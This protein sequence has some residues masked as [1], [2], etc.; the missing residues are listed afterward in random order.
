MEGR[1]YYLLY[2]GQREQPIIY[3]VKKIM[4]RAEYIY[5]FINR[6]IYIYI[7]IISAGIIL[8][9]IIFKEQRDNAM[10]I[11]KYDAHMCKP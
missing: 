2:N 10:Y 4:G 6:Y 1:A 5:T 3:H 9:F 8:S 7:Y 11:A